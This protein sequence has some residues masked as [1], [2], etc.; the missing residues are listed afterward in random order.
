LKALFII[1]IDKVKDLEEKISGL[2][3]NN[4]A[5][6]SK[7]SELE[8]IVK[9]NRIEMEKQNSNLKVIVSQ[10]NTLYN[11]M[12]AAAFKSERELIARNYK[13]NELTESKIA[14]HKQIKK[15]QE[16]KEQLMFQ[17]TDIKNNLDKEVGTCK[18]LAFEIVQLKQEAEDKASLVED[19]LEKLNTARNNLTKDKAQIIEKLNNLRTDIKNLENELLET[20]T[21]YAEHREKSANT[22]NILENS[23]SVLEGELLKI[24]D[25]HKEL[26]RVHTM[27]E[28]QHTIQVWDI[29]IFRSINTMHNV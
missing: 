8:I 5:L 12:Q 22:T 4:S 14:D 19:Q 1:T 13:I 29:F 9:A 7:K 21:Q 24:N 3:T 11:E 2:T 10:K 23:I 28:T 6:S 16:I 18:N 25:E 20:Q 17:I 27:L 26:N 15:F